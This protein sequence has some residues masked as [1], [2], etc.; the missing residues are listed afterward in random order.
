[1]AP[2]LNCIFLP[3]GAGF[4][5]HPS[6]TLQR[7]FILR[8]YSIPY[9]SPLCRWGVCHYAWQCK[10]TRCNV[11]IALSSQNSS[12]RRHQHHLS[13]GVV[14]KVNLG[15]LNGNHL[16]SDQIKPTNSLRSSQSKRSSKVNSLR[17]KNIFVPTNLHTSRL[18]KVL[19]CGRERRNNYKH[20]YSL[21]SLNA[22]LPPSL[23]LEQA[24]TC[25]VSILSSSSSNT[26]MSAFSVFHSYR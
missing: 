24:A 15:H 13:I 3:E 1:M 12:Q 16:S 20:R 7:S 10:D 6:P 8:S 26:I 5:L 21:N 22:S 4:D 2:N 18:D 14:N 23:L 9:K 19:R 11:Q 17:A 25:A